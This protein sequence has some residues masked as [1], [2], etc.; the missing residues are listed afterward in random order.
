MTAL[1]PEVFPIAE[2]TSAHLRVDIAR[3]AAVVLIGPWVHAATNSQH[4]S[5]VTRRDPDEDFMR[6]YL[7]HAWADDW[8]SPE[9]A[10]YDEL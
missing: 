2:G 4:P 5:A 3:P 1:A 9:D 6:G 8:D 10:V 7:S